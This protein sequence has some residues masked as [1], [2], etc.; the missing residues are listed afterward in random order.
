MWSVCG[1]TKTTVPT[2][3]VTKVRDYFNCNYQIFLIKIKQCIWVEGLHISSSKWHASNCYTFWW[4][5]N[6]AKTLYKNL[7]FLY[8][9]NIILSISV[10][11]CYTPFRGV[12]SKWYWIIYVVL[13]FSRW[14]LCL[15]IT[16][17]VFLGCKWYSHWI[18][19]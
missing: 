16:H 13:Y 6:L 10:P 14:K 5:K 8:V 12:G 9:G 4:H 2:S 17:Y 15:E 18:F 11:R 3:S 1:S 7:V 19:L